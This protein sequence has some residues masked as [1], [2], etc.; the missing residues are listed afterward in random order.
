MQDI[1]K[2][3]VKQEIE[4]QDRCAQLTTSQTTELKNLW[5]IYKI[6]VDLINNYTTFITTALLPSQS[7]QDILIGEEIIEIYRIERRLWVYGTITFLDVL[8]NFSNFM[9][10]YVC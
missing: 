3:I 7:P 10:T 6:N 2:L 4:L 1:Y 9:D 8:K 5:T